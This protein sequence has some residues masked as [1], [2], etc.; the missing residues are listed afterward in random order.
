MTLPVSQMI[1]VEEARNRILS[2]VNRLPSSVTKLDE[3]LGLVLATNIIAPFDIPPLDNTAM[4]GYAVRA[5]DTEKAKSTNPIPLKVI[6]NLAAGYIAKEE[7]GKDEAIRIMTGAPIPKGADSIVP[8]EETDE[9]GGKPNVKNIEGTFVKVFKAAKVSANIRFRGEDIRENQ[10]ILEA[11]RTIRA[12][13]IGVLA[14]TGL[15]EIEVFRRPNIAILSTGDEIVSPGKLRK[16]GQIYDANTKMLA[17]LV[18]QFGGIPHILGI[19]KDT[20]EDLTMKLRSGFGTDMIVTSAG[21]SRG[22]FDIVK[23][24]LA[25]EGVIDF[26]TVRMKPG[27]PLAFGTF[28]TP[29]GRSI[30][31]LG[32]PG[33]PVSSMV[34][35][36]LFGRPALFKMMGRPDWKRTVIQAVTQD[37]IVNTDGRRFFARCIITKNANGTFSANLTGPQGSGILTSMSAANG[38]TIIPEETPVVEPGETINVMML[39]WEQTLF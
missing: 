10:V 6:A 1:S 25:K 8:F 7:V 13:E 18:R 22:D 39:D 34:A 26:W 17:A 4:D 24:V 28:H 3:A 35:F 36:E 31:H 12:S 32:L 15:T 14:S 21:V 37:R 30:P 29:D 38:L 27:K 2:L 33:N 19:A 20:V 16:P 23:N 5:K 11:G 9:Q